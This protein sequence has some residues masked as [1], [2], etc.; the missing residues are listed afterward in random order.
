MKNQIL[1]LV[2]LGLYNSIITVD[3]KQACEEGKAVL[4]KLN[5]FFTNSQNS[6]DERFTNIRLKMSSTGNWHICIFVI[7]SI[8]RKLQDIL[9]LLYIWI[10]ERSSFVTGLTPCLFHNEDTIYVRHVYA[11]SPLKVVYDR[12]SFRAYYC[13][14]LSIILVSVTTENYMVKTEQ[15][16]KFVAQQ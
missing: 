4:D 2:I 13:L 5:V 9:N 16:Q 7:L 3:A 1:I 10:N 8:L 14:F 15:K 11:Y 6:E 12:N